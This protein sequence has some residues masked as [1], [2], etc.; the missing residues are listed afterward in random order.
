M[1]CGARL[2]D[3]RRRVTEV[4]TEV[5]GGSTGPASDERIGDV[6]PSDL[7]LPAL[8]RVETVSPARQDWPLGRGSDLHQSLFDDLRYGTTSRPERDDAHFEPLPGCN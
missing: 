6:E 1:C 3:S 8:P 5:L 4:A 2:S 7:G